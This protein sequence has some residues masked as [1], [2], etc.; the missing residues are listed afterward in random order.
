MS[1]E[2]MSLNEKFDAG[3]YTGVAET[4]EE[5]KTLY[6]GITNQTGPLSDTKGKTLKVVNFYCEVIAMDSDIKDDDGNTITIKEPATRIVIFTDDGKAYG[7]VSS[8]IK[9]S[10]MKICQIYGMPAEW[11]EPL[12]V[13][14]KEINRNKNRIYTFELV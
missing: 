3:F 10:L 13:T 5:K 6:N 11:E 12:Q 7:C 9:N 2:I 8:G 14:L 4:V 1:N